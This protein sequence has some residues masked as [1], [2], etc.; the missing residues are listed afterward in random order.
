MAIKSDNALN[1][2]LKLYLKYALWYLFQHV[3]NRTKKRS[4]KRTGATSD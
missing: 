2:L 1:P 4:F 3:P